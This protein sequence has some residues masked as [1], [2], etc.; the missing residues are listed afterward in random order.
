MCYC[1]FII[2]FICEYIF[3]NYFLVVINFGVEMG[4]KMDFE[5]YLVVVI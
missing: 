2:I 4:F 3:D 1:N 5:W